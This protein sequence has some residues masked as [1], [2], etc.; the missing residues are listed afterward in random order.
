MKTENRTK[1]KIEKIIAQIELE[2]DEYEKEAKT[3]LILKINAETNKL[4][5]KQLTT[6][7]TIRVCM[8]MFKRV[9]EFEIVEEFFKTRCY[10]LKND[11]EVFKNFSVKFLDKLQKKFEMED[12]RPAKNIDQHLINIHKILTRSLLDFRSL[13]AEAIANN[14][15]IANTISNNTYSV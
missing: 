9:P 3:L 6:L 1:S 8:D 12:Y 14:I 10:I 5:T 7:S 15:E 4:A 2:L 13:L 11:V